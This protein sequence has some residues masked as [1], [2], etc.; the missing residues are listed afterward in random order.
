MKSSGAFHVFAKWKDAPVHAFG[1]KTKP[2]IVPPEDKADYQAIFEELLGAASAAREA[3]ASGQNVHV[4]PMNFSRRYGSRGHRPV[5]LWVSLCGAGSE[6][7]SQMPQVYAIGSDRG[8]EIGF[9]A[10]IDEADYHDPNVKARNRLVVPL[11]N[12]KLPDPRAPLTTTLDQALA[13]QGGWHF[14]TKTRL[15]AG[16]PGWDRFGS[17]SEMFAALKGSADATGGGTICRVFD[18][19][20]LP[21]LDLDA[22]F[23]TALTIF[24][25]LIARCAPT[26]WD[27]QI[28]L[29]QD[30]VADLEDPT[31]FDPLNI[32]DGRTKILAQ[33]ARRQGQATFRKTLFKA[34]DGRCAI[35]GTAVPSVLQAAHI[36]PYLGVQTNHVTNGLLLRADIHTLFDLK[37]LRIEPETLRIRISPGLQETIYAQYDGQTLA[38]P[39][40]AS[41]RPSIAALSQQFAA[42]AMSEGL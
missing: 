28:L 34:Y 37:L 27:V 1:S 24:L 11:L 14:N 25:P 26:P 3:T 4:K 18:F 12:A 23:A 41:Q 20:Q 22:E 32:L 13:A 7:L 31:P 42:P 35:T 2:S 17:L 8:L 29:A 21:G 10:S 19:G 30:T 15:V 6:A 40:K 9:A 16:D 38:A 33:V 39:A 5:D 36:T